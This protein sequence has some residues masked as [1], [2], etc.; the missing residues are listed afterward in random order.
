[1]TNKVLSEVV[2]SN[3]DVT[4]VAVSRRMRSLMF[5]AVLTLLY[6][7]FILTFCFS[8]SLLGMMGGSGVSVGIIVHPLLICTMI[9]LSGIYTYVS[10]RIEESQSGAHHE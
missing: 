3:V 8:P 1:M 2:S 7:T 9:L 6:F 5:A 10:D 4:R